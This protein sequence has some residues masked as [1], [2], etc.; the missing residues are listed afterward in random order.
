[1]GAWSSLPPFFTSV[2]L[3]LRSAGAL[4]FLFPLACRRDFPLPGS[5]GRLLILLANKVL[6][7]AMRFSDVTKLSV[8]ERLAHTRDWPAS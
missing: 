7:L 2:F 4:I 1:M 8:Q 5:F 6:I 3:P